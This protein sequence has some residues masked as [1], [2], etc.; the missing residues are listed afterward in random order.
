MKKIYAL[1]PAY[2][3]SENIES[4]IDSWYKQRDNL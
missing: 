3:E 4:L 1:L 2:N